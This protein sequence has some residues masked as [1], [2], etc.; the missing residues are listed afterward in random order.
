MA[1]NKFKFCFL[2][3]SGTFPPQIFSICVWLNSWM[4]NLWIWKA[5][6]TFFE[7]PVTH[8]HANTIFNLHDNLAQLQGSLNG[9]SEAL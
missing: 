6:Y 1:C 8:K 9:A 4:W 2:E 7:S 5:D 3:L